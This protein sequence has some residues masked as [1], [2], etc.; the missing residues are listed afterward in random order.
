MKWRERDY[1]RTTQMKKKSNP[2]KKKTNKHWWDVVLIEFVRA[3]IASPSSISVQKRSA[4]TLSL[5]DLV[6]ALQCR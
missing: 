6:R 3:N 4:S 1:L 2:S 5:S